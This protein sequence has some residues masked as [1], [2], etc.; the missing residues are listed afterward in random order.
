MKLKTIKLHKVDNQGNEKE[1]A[2]TSL[3][4][5]ITNI[6]YRNDLCPNPDCNIIVGHYYNGEYI[7]NACGQKYVIKD[8]H[9]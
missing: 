1:I 3:Q 7:C 2:K 5:V 6:T 4:S 8:A 9:D